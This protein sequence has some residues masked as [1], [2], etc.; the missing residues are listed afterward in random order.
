MVYTFHT[1]ASVRNKRMMLENCAEVSMGEDTKGIV[2][3]YLTHD[4]LFPDSV[5][6]FHHLVQSRRSIPCRLPN[7]RTIAGQ[8]S[9]LVGANLLV[10]PS[11]FLYPFEYL[12]I[13]SSQR[14]PSLA[15]SLVAIATPKGPCCQEQ[16]SLAYRSGRHWIA[17]KKSLRQY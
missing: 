3:Y 12:H 7:S 13:Q 9:F 17:F 11:T 8:Q 5:L 2:R 10:K 15:R 1:T 6:P 4:K 14:C 16:T